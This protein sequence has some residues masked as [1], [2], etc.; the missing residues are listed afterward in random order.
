MLSGGR[1][2]PVAVTGADGATAI[3]TLPYKAVPAGPTERGRRAEREPETGLR[4]ACRPVTHRAADRLRQP[5]REA[6]ETVRRASV[7]RSAREE[8][9][10]ARRN[11]LSACRLRIG[12]AQRG[13]SGP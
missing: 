8:R 10:G 9:A 12:G 2:E 7:R 5:D 6:C 1:V 13:R 3:L 11:G 4:R